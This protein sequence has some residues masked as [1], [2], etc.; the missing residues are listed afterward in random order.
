MFNKIL[1]KGL[2]LLLPFVFFFCPCMAQETTGTD[3]LLALLPMQKEDTIKVQLYLDI[4]NNYELNDP[5]TAAQYYR[6]AGELSRKLNYSRG[7][8]KYISNYTGLLNQ[9]AQFDSSLLLNK[10]AIALAQTLN[11]K[12]LLAKCY[13]NTGNVYQYTSDYENALQHYETAK[14]YFEQIGNKKLIARMCDVMQNTYREL[15]QP[16]KA[17]QLGREAV[18]ILRNEGDP[19]LLGLALVNLGNNF[20]KANSDS[21]L[22]YYTE[23]LAIFKD[24][25][26]TRGIMT[27]FLDIGNIYLH[28]YNADS[29]KP[30]Y[31]KAL[32]LARQLQEPESEC[33]A[34]RGM[35]HYFLYTMNFAEAKKYITNALAIS[36]SLSLKYEHT[37]NLKSLSAILYALQDIKGAEKALDSSSISEE[38]INNEEIQ[39]KTL[40]LSKKFETEKKDALIQLQQSQLQ[41]KSTLNYFLASGAIGLLV[42]SLLGYRNYKNRQKLQ[43]S[44][45]EELETE[46]QLAATE[47]VL[48]GEEQERS[49]L[50]KDLHDGLGGML[51]GIKYSLSNMKQNL[52]MTPDNT[53]AFDRSLDML[54][55]SIKEMRRVAHNMM[56]EVLVRYGL[57]E[58]LKEFCSEIDRSGVLQVSYLSIKLEDA[59]LEQT[60]ALTIYRIVQE[61]VNNVIKHAA[62]KSAL[63]QLHYSETENLLTITVEDDGKGLDITILARSGGIGW[64]SIYNRVDF[65]KGKAD[66]K[67]APDNGT[68]VLITIP[69]ENEKL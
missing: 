59:R 27:C 22:K 3:S 35:S 62:A 5:Q 26:F 14:R 53:Q 7:V 69:V 19:F 49:R 17:M 6:L 15:N 25:N 9:K 8:I 67:S 45:I 57:D 31:E 10:Q 16:E 1:M 61:L 54:D 43:Q 33:I 66:V 24:Q 32:Q 34:Y 21:A 2:L 41:Q 42:I 12:L 52:I 51:S 58:A 36:D 20:N 23:A 65:L 29:M 55:S 56:P 18:Q 50:A 38:E 64:S 63:V 37:K 48:K 39:Q 4:G 44:K 68:S 11:D 40:T 46:K 30:C 60:T 28:R 47:A 13:A